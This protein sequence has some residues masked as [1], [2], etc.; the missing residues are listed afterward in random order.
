MERVEIYIVE[1]GGGDTYYSLQGFVSLLNIFRSGRVQGRRG[2]KSLRRRGITD[3][4]IR[5][6][7]R[8]LHKREERRGRQNVSTT[9]IEQ[10]KSQSRGPWKGG[11]EGGTLSGKP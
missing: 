10:V 9:C 4:E 5:K 1:K 3:G 11:T 2:G 7:K 6:E 8:R